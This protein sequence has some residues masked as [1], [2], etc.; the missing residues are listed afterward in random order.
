MFGARSLEYLPLDKMMFV[1]YSIGMN[2]ELTENEIG[3]VCAAL[4]IASDLQQQ[5]VRKAKIYEDK[6]LGSA[7][8][9]DAIG[10]KYVFD[11]LRKKLSQ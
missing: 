8:E 4:M 3:I 7:V 6:N 11:Q 1:C 2:I 10:R 5:R 9:N